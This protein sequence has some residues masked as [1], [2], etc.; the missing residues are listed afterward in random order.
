M[1]IFNIATW[2]QQ[3]RYKTVAC[4][5]PQGTPLIKDIALNNSFTLSGA[6]IPAVGGYAVIYPEQRGANAYVLRN[7]KGRIGGKSVEPGVSIVGEK[8]GDCTLMLVPV[9]KSTQIIAGDY[10]ETDMF[11]MPYGGGSQD[12]KPAQKASQDYAINPPK[13]TSVRKGTKVNNFPTRIKLDKN[14][15]ADFTITGGM[16]CI[17]I[18][19]EGAKDYKNLRIY[20]GDHKLIELSRPG[21]KDGYQTFTDGKNNFG[22][23]FLVTT[24]G[25]EHRYF[26]EKR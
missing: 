8:K 20:D 26:V 1:R 13:V 14:G 2:V 25:K 18:I 5:G 19:V 4:G 3:L 24:D 17:P 6:K 15:A 21:E 12:Y 10:I 7:F 23:V 11:I 9:T 16:D 22:S